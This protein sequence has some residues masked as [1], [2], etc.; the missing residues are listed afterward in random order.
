MAEN[1]QLINEQ[2]KHCINNHIP[3]AKFCVTSIITLGSFGFAAA[4]LATGGLSAPLAPFYTSL[5]SGSIA[6]WATPPSAYINKK[7]NL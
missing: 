4:M 2:P 5:I 1:I 6:Y 3:C 7:D